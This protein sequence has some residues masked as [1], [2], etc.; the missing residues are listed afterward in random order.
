MRWHQ[1][2]HPDDVAG[3]ALVDSSHPDQEY[4]L[5]VDGWRL[6]RPRWWLR[7]WLQV[8]RSAVRPL[9]WAR[10]RSRG[11]EIPPHLRRGLPPEL[12]EGAMAMRLGRRHHR[13][14]VR[15]MAAFAG[16]AAEVGRV[17]GDAP[18]SL[19]Q[20]PL[21]VI[22][23]DPNTD[24]PWPP[25]AEATW[26]QMQAELPLLSERSIHLHAASGDHFVHRADPDL[27]VRAIADL[28]DQVR[29]G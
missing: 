5:R 24:L 29:S 8:A 7:W 15:E 18:G 16:L 4:R 14:S 1:A 22:T 23:R 6:S 26:Q 21:V 27:V 10:L 12:A 13:A 19:G 20:L 28:V 25:E 11:N 9:G 2:T 17:A 3:L